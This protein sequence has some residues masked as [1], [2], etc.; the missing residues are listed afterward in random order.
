M[1]EDGNP[2]GVTFT[3]SFL[4]LLLSEHFFYLKKINHFQ[5]KNLNIHDFEDL[6]PCIFKNLLWILE[7]DVSNLDQSFSYF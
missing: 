6:D 2:V 1:L 3:K 5:D 7:N 4:K